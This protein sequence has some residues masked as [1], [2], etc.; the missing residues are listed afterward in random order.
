[1]EN[2]VPNYK[3]FSNL[4]VKKKRKNKYIGIINP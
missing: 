2:H 1:M 4:V 3:A